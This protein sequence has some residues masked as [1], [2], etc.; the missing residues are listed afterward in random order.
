MTVAAER[1]PAELTGREAMNEAVPGVPDLFDAALAELSP[2]TARRIFEQ[3]WGDIYQDP[4]LTLRE[5]TIAAI[6]GLT[7][8]GGAETNLTLQTH[9]A[10]NAGMTPSEI[11]AIVELAA[12]FA[13]F[14]RAQS[15]LTT[16]GGVLQ[17]RAGA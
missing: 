1:S 10:L 8:L 2:N 17:Q 4:T 11:V 6:A 12:T 7:A 3:I 9:I 16:V 15:A 14:P 5:R 13:G